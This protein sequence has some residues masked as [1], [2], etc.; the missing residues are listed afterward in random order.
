MSIEI[1]ESEKFNFQI[2]T[3]TENDLKQINEIDN[4]PEEHEAML[5]LQKENAGKLLVVRCGNKIAGYVFVYYDH[6]SA[7]FPGIKAPFLEDLMVSPEFRGQGLGK[8]L[9]QKCEEEIKNQNGKELTFAVLASNEQAIDF[10][11]KNGYIK[12]Q[13]TE[14]EPP[15][16]ENQDEKEV[17]YYFKKELA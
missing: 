1:N 11:T 12:I 10:Y 3:A 5:K 13:G 16:Q 7:H 4:R 8:I 2:D 9:L 14:F 6:Q 15:K 17:G